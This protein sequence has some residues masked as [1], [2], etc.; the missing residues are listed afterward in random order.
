MTEPGKYQAVLFDFD[1]TY[2]DTAPDM[3]AALNRVLADHKR[4]MM[5]LAAARAYVSHGS[6][7]LI[8]LGFA[9]A[10]EGR[11]TRLIKQ[12]LAAYE[13]DVATHTR[14]FPGMEAWTGWLEARGVAWGIVTNKPAYLTAKV[15]KKMHL[16]HP[17]QCVVAGDS[18][19]RR[20]PHPMPVLHAAALL[21]KSAN[22]CIYVGDARGDIAAGRAAGMYTVI[23]NYGYILPDDD[24]HQWDAH[25]IADSV[26][27]LQQIVNDLLHV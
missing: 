5:P 25:S 27:Q 10:G 22:R 8:K 20:K 19:L 6:R 13:H 12:F 24:P 7:G 14:P 1:G 26:D 15:L 21:R 2:A 16:K 11:T 17:P 23:A 4:D 3:V 18:L 9:H